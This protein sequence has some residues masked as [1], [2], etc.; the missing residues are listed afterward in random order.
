[1]TR[2][3]SGPNWLQTTVRMEENLPGDWSHFFYLAMGPSGVRLLHDSRNAAARL[4]PGCLRSKGPQPR[5][6][7][8]ERVGE[9]IDVSVDRRPSDRQSER[10]LGID[11]HGLEHRRRL[12]RLR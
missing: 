6:H 5:H 3:L 12:Q 2:S 1:M 7:S 9:S 10:M 11:S 4:P 8:W